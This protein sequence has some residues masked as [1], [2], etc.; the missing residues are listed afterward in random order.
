MVR[1]RR[2]AQLFSAKPRHP[3]LYQFASRASTWVCSTPVPPGRRDLP[4]RRHLQAP[5]LVL[6]LHKTRA[7]RHCARSMAHAD[8]EWAALEPK[9]VHIVDRDPMRI[10]KT[11]E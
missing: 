5:S 1:G 3:W 7:D 4:G 6:L 11:H 2:L 10:G 9:P 8:D